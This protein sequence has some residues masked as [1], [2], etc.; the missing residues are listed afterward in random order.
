M[1]IDYPTASASSTIEYG[2]DGDE[3]CDRKSCSDGKA[4]YPFRSYSSGDAKPSRRELARLRVTL[5]VIRIIGS[6]DTA[7]T[8]RAW[9]MGLS[10]E[11]N[12]QSPA[13]AI[14]AGQDADTLAAARAYIRNS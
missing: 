6:I 12:D 4:A 7:S 2:I 10:P 9:F 13:E 11:L 3:R 14:A 8:V 1:E 5:D